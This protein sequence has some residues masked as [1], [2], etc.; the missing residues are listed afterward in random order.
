MFK[1]KEG[2]GGV[3]FVKMCVDKDVCEHLDFNRLNGSMLLLVAECIVVLL[4]ACQFACRAV[5]GFC[6]LII[7]LLIDWL[8]NFVE[9]DADLRIGHGAQKRADQW[10]CMVFGVVNVGTW[11][12]QSLLFVKCIECICL[13]ISDDL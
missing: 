2:G 4:T 9:V 10:R 6:A 5:R 11:T 12:V 7:I 8:F 3:S 1:S 13:E